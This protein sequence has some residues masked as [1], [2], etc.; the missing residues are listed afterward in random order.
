MQLDLSLSDSSDGEVL[1]SVWLGALV[2]AALEGVIE[3]SF[4]Y[5][6]IESFVDRLEQGRNFTDKQI[7]YIEQMY[8]DY[9]V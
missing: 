6:A 1:L 3:S 2:E 9:C 4:D 7:D 5:E 8:N